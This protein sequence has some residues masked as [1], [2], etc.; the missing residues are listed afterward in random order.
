MPLHSMTGFAR[1]DGSGE[2]HRWTWELRSVNG[3]GLDVR[4]R[5]PPGFEGLELPVRERAGKGLAR[6]NVQATLNLQAEG[7]SSRVRINR[8][9]LDEMLAAMQV[10]AARTAAAPPTLDGILSLR[11]V[12]EAADGD[13]DAE[14]RERLTA[15]ML[16]DLDRALAA[17]V[18]ARAQEGDVLRA[19]LVARL[20]QIAGLTATAE[21]APA[22]KPEAI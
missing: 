13:I 21:A 2:G 3:K 12:V 1:S 15:R 22:R 4:L 19:I 5:L 7:A 9:V 18:A 14:T 16:A 10:I 20:D 17:L 11:G 6:G 8:E